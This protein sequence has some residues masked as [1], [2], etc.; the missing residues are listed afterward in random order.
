MDVRLHI[1]S[2]LH[3]SQQG[4][5]APAVH[6]DLSILAGDIARPEA[7]MKWAAGLGRPVLYVP[8][9][10]EFYGSSIPETR[11][12]LAEQAA[13]LGIHLLDQGQIVLHGVRFLGTTLWTDFQLFGADK[14]AEAKAQAA[15]F[16]RDFQVVRN[17]DGDIYTPDDSIALFEEQSAWLDQA[18]DEP[19]DG[20]TV[21]ISHHAP[22]PQSVHPRFADSLVSA[23]FASDCSAL[24]G[25]ASLWVH[26]HT[27]D[28]FDYS[29]RGTRVICNPRGYCRDGVNENPA[30][31]PELRID[32]PMRP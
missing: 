22:A 30:F 11:R 3:L 29:V 25:R 7:A 21:V 23:G 26:G 4:M 17:A 18:L 31:D 32:I 1:L 13:R 20:P 9:N 15:A 6:A 24:M 27:H 8:G 5:P 12:R 19:F 28:S 10:H 16:M 2:D 14:A